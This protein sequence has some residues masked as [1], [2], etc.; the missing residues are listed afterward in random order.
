MSLEYHW[1]GEPS[2]E[3][4][5][6]KYIHNDKYWALASCVYTKKTKVWLMRTDFIWTWKAIK[7]YKLDIGDDRCRD[8][9]FFE[10][11][12]R[13]IRCC[14]LGMRSSVKLRATWLMRSAGRSVRTS[15]PQAKRRSETEGQRKRERERERACSAACVAVRASHYTPTRETFYSQRTQTT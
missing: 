7:H 12:Y 11:L 14:G 1:T 2:W 8:W 3:Q 4:I 13:T 6:D 10:R 9:W 5:N 15:S